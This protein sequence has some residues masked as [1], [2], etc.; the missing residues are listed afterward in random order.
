V[1]TEILDFDEMIEESTDPLGSSIS[2][3]K[4]NPFFCSNEH[5][6]ELWR[7]RRVIDF[8]SD[9]PTTLQSGSGVRK[10]RVRGKGL[11]EYRPFGRN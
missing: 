11:P 7:Q 10:T 6:K 4:D 1:E 8:S 5:L 2:I 3:T 9:A